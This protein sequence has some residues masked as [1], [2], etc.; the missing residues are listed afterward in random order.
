MLVRGTKTPTVKQL[1]FDIK[2]SIHNRFDIEVV[3]ASTGKVKQKAFGHNVICNNLWTRL[4]SSTYD[5]FN[6]IFYG[7]GSGTPSSSDTSLFS[8]IGYGAVGN[9]SYTM[10]YENGVFSLKKSIQLTAATAAGEVITEVG[11]AY[12]TSATSLCTHAM[13]KDMNGNPISIEKTDTD[14]INI[15]ATVFVRY[16]PMGY[17]NGSIFVYKDFYANYATKSNLAADLFA[18]FAGNWHSDN[19]FLYRAEFCPYGGYGFRNAYSRG[20][21]LEGAARVRLSRTLDSNNRKISITV[22]RLEANA[23]NFGGIRTIALLASWSYG[24]E[25]EY[26]WPQVVM[27]PGGS[28]F[29]YSTVTNEAVG[30]GDGT[31]VDFAL[32]FSFAKNAR[33]YIN[34]VE[35]TEFTLE[36]GPVSTTNWKCYME[37][38]HE[39]STPER[40]IR[41]FYGVGRDS[42]HYISGTTYFYN[43]L[44]HI[45]LRTMAFY[46]S[47]TVYASN[48]FATWV[49]VGASTSITIAEAYRKYKYWKLVPSA[50][51][52][53]SAIT[54]DT[55]N[56]NVLHLNSAPASGAV[57]TAD[58]ECDVIAKDANHVFDMTVTIQLGEYTEAQ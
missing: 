16:D 53:I 25:G 52:Y 7:G 12:G 38:L 6:Y 17:D 4:F 23:G 44:S 21:S 3:D 46:K 27:Q 28:W 30:T 13:L 50:E 41:M 58:Y 45:G 39:S 10:D 29:P 35:T 24:N 49:Q 9:G 20:E 56:T 47:T 31:T 40:H 32:D 1:N 26:M 37:G 48:D 54:P 34:G 2:A 11:I 55:Y 22:G 43:P 36:Y 57:I 42:T 14:V 19:Y 5:Y 51:S 33:V 8:R 18:W 15:Y